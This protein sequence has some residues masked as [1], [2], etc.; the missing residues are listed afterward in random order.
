MSA[1]QEFKG[2][3]IKDLIR[4]S[5]YKFGNYDVSV[6]TRTVTEEIIDPI[7]GE[8]SGEIPR[9][10]NGC[11]LLQNGPGAYEIGDVMFNHVFDG[12]ALLHRF[13]IVDGKVTYQNRF[14]K[15][16]AY[17]AVKKENRIVFGEFGTAPDPVGNIFQRFLSLFK[18]KTDSTT[19]NTL[20]TIFPI[21]NDFYAFT[22][23]PKIRKF[24]TTTLE[25]LNLVNLKEYTG[26]V[27]QPAHAIVTE[28]GSLYNI[29]TS[30][31]S[32]G[33]QYILYCIPNVENK[34]E[35]VKIVS[36]ITPK[37]KTYPSYMHSF[38]ITENYFIVIEQPFTISIYELTKSLFIRKNFLDAFKWFENEPTYVHLIDRKTGVKI[39]T[40]ETETFFF[41][42][43]IN[44]YEDNDQVVLDIICYEG[45]ELVKGLLLQNMKQ[46]QKAKAKTKMLTSRPLRFVFPLK[47]STENK[48]DKNLVYLKGTD[49]TAYMQ[50]SGTVICFPELLC[51][52]SFE[53]GTVYYDKYFGKK[54]KFFYGVGMDLYTEF[55][56]Q[57]IKVN[58]ETKE[59]QIWQEENVYPSEPLFI[60]SPNSASEDD[61]II[62]SAL[63]KGNENTN[64]IAFLI[65]DGKTFREIGRC[66]FKNLP[67]AITKVFHGWFLDQRK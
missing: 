55:P 30:I 38:G 6:W 50:Q 49:A 51:N 27:Y 41:F 11:S 26:I 56:E 4:E 5:D 67:S 32:A 53:F 24:N 29:G 21:G 39:H 37:R 22:E 23:T 20:V 16:N 31:S 42:H 34:F 9:W 46:L 7:E 35:N 33:A 25:T 48:V 64:F 1:K 54:Y 65:L 62:I 3:K 8:I 63:L 66:E 45:P 44:A 17:E 60:P 10:I 18:T 28:D 13:N 40:F 47:Y 14:V 19:D 58:T 43:T 2:N 36:K 15:S 52:H 59:V 57:L 61:G 12:M